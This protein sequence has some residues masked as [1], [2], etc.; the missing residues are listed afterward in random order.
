MPVEDAMDAVSEDAEAKVSSLRSSQEVAKVM[1]EK[2]WTVAKK[3]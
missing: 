1:L 2:P 3:I